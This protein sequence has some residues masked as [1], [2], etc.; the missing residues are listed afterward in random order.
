MC[1]GQVSGE[2]VCNSCCCLVV[3]P[4]KVL[5]VWLSSSAK[6]H[7]VF[8]ILL[9]AQRGFVHVS[10]ALRFLDERHSLSVK[11]YLFFRDR[12]A[13]T[14]IMNFYLCSIVLPLD[15]NKSLINLAPLYCHLN[16]PQLQSYS[17]CL[18]IIMCKGAIKKAAWA[19]ARAGWERGS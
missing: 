11:S 7:T 19:S 4:L 6:G 17:C 5:T 16:L 12:R 8:T 1:S 14:A 3:S 15:G 13:V 18:W 9:W 10:R 2:A